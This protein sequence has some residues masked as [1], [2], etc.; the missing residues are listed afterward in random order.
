V[1]STEGPVNTIGAA[2]DD[3]ANLV[4][5]PATGQV[6]LTGVTKAGTG[7]DTITFYV[8]SAS[9]GIR[10][11]TVKTE[12]VDFTCVA[13]ASDAECVCNLYTALTVTAPITGLSV[14][15]SDGTCSDE[16]LIF[17][18]TS[19]TAV[20]ARAVASDTT[21]TVIVE[22]THG[23]VVVPA[24]NA[25]S[26][27]LL[28]N[29]SAAN[30]VGLSVGY[31]SGAYTIAFPGNGS[32]S[33]LEIASSGSSALF[34]N[35]T[36]YASITLGSM[37]A[38]YSMNNNYANITAGTF[39]IPSSFNCKLLTGTTR[40]Q[41]NNAMIVACG[42]VKT[43]DILAV[44]LPAKVELDDMKMVVETAATNTTDLVM[45]C[46]RAG[47][48]YDDYI[49]DSNLQA[50]A[51]TIYGNAAGERGTNL[52]GYDT[53]SWTATTPVYCHLETTDAGKNLSDVLTSTGSLYFDITKY[54][55]P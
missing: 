28:F 37:T 7:S 1:I 27:G 44:T 33:P 26:P 6:T 2:N 51:N 50:A 21:N 39:A 20:R 24:G 49:T 18:P 52:T 34:W 47:A 30:P 35:G 12:G 23:S 13:A 54:I 10:T 55:Q 17:Y 5:A 53:V 48:A 31:R 36:S 11:A 29:T 41:W 38:A 3:G 19:G 16:T 46:G 9:T 43:C 15:R 40:A 25:A 32:T 8:T 42:A 45:S 4:L 14:A 22:D